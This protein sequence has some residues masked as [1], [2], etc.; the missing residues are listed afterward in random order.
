MG[1]LC[2]ITLSVEHLWDSVELAANASIKRLD[3][4]FSDG[5]LS[6]YDKILEATPNLRIFKTQYM[7]ETSFKCLMTN[8]KALEELYVYNY[9]ASLHPDKQQFSQL[10][11][12]KSWN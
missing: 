2:Q 7:N 10:K 1:Q 12:F 5:P 4:S 11:K 8:C 9:E 6:V 3:L